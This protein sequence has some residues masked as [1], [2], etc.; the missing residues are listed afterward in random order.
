M[1]EDQQKS[2][3]SKRLSQ[4]KISSYF[5]GCVKRPVAT[6]ITQKIKI[7]TRNRLNISASMDSVKTTP[8]KKKFSFEPAS[9]QKLMISTLS[10][11]CNNLINSIEKRK[12]PVAII[13][14]DEDDGF[15]SDGNVE[16]TKSE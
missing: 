2:Q 11:D 1:C 3:N 16:K 15:Q 4:T 6:E 10:I 7:K 13:S 5:T 8:K 12:L 14:D 9:N